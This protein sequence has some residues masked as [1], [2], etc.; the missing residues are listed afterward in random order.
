MRN[1]FFSCE[2]NFKLS[3]N[4]VKINFYF[5]HYPHYFLQT[6]CMTFNRKSTITKAAMNLVG[7]IYSIESLNPA[8]SHNSYDQAHSK[9]S[10]KKA[11][12]SNPSVVQIIFSCQIPKNT[13]CLVIISVSQLLL[14]LN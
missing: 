7:N 6:T 1:P 9:D 10:S 4:K 11:T 8:R 14:Q 12:S 13:V 2:T 5:I 3:L